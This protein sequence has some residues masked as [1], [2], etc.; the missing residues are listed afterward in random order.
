MHHLKS[1]KYI[2]LSVLTTAL[3]ISSESGTVPV[4]AF[5]VPTATTSSLGSTAH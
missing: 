2:C 1:F 4:V 3:E 5:Q